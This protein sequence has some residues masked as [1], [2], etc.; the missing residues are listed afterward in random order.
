[1]KRLQLKPGSGRYSAGICG[2]TSNYEAG[3]HHILTAL[4]KGGFVE[5]MWKIS[6]RGQE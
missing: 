6:D 3:H 2:I 1:M 5:E 4:A